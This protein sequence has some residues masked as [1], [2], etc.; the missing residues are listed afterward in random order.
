MVFIKEVHEMETSTI[1]LEAFNK[2][3]KNALPIDNEI[4]QRA[5]SFTSYSI[6]SI[7][8]NHKEHVKPTY[9]EFK[10]NKSNTKVAD[11]L[12]QYECTII[13]VDVDSVMLKDFFDVQNYNYKAIDDTVNALYEIGKYFGFYKEMTDFKYKKIED[14]YTP[15]KKIFYLEQKHLTKISLSP[16]MTEKRSTDNLKKKFAKIHNNFYISEN[17]EIHPIVSVWLPYSSSYDF[18]VKLNLHP[19]QEANQKEQLEKDKLRFSKT[20]EEH[21]ES[22]LKRKL[23]IKKEE[24]AA[25]TLEEKLNYLIVIEM[26]A[27]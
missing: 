27:I 10:F 16:M 1:Y 2:I 7:Y 12:Y 21:F 24:I 13:G 22:V 14:L 4:I 20:L 3:T 26:D 11:Q 9:F 8:K 18:L 23:K 17:Y 19:S 25:M 5:G 15:Y 6:E